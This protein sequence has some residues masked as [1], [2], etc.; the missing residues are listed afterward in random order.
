MT[1]PTPAAM[2]K[3]Y[4]IIAECYTN[5]DAPE[6]PHKH[7]AKWWQ[8]RIAR[9][10]DEARKVPEGQVSRVRKFCNDYLNME[11]IDEYDSGMRASAR[12]VLR[13]ID[14]PDAYVWFSTRAAAEA[15]RDAKGG[16]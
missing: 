16:G 9:A 15:A 6:P 13:L 11:P 3:A 10:I 1:D 12:H 7:D 4:A 2:E 14:E 5:P 8:L